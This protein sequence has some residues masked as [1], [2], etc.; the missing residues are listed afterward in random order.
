MPQTPLERLYD[1]ACENNIQIEQM[2]LPLTKS[3]SAPVGKKCYIAIDK[4]PM[5]TREEKVCV[6]HEIGHCETLSFY[7]PNNS[8]DVKGRHEYRADRWS[9]HELIPIEEYIKAIEKGNTEIWQLAECF[10]VTEDFIVKVDY[11]YKCEGKLPY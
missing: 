3:I 5:K 10:D 11:V 7:N 8:L 1:L 9:V 2:N 6:A 4:K